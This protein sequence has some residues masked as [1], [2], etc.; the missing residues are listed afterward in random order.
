MNIIIN[1]SEVYQ[2]VQKMSAIAGSMLSGNESPKFDDVLIT[3]KDGEALDTFWRDGVGS[4]IQLFIRYVSNDTTDYDLTQ[5]DDTEELLIS[6]DM[7]DAFNDQLTGS[8]TTSTKMM[9]ACNIMS[10]WMAI[11]YPNAV[12]KYKDDA[13]GYAADIKKKLLFRSSPAQNRST[14]FKSDTDV[15]ETTD[16][17]G[18]KAAETSVSPTEDYFTEK[19]AETDVEQSADYFG[20]K[21]ADTDVSPVDDYFSAKSAETNV[22]QSTDYFGSKTSETSVSPTEDYF[23]EKISDTPVSTNTDYFGIKEAD[24]LI[25][26]QYED[27]N[28]NPA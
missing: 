18:S 20:S 9:L 26:E 10:G 25:L 16:Y 2:E 21:T 6:A 4:A 15:S 27:C 28:I 7:P 11:K 5:Y 3:D 13:L 19:S 17:F 12:Q 8:I 1:K 23:S 14:D 22:E 24:N